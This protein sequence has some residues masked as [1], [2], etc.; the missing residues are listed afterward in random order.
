VIDPVIVAEFIE[1]TEEDLDRLVVVL[2]LL[3]R[4]PGT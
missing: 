2:S 1:A 3:V 4:F